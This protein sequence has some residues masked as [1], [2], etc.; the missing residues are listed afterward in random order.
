[1]STVHNE[2][3]HFYVY[4]DASPNAKGDVFANVAAL[5]GDYRSLVEAT[6]EMRDP[7]DV[8]GCMFEMQHRLE[9]CIRM[10]C[11]RYCIDRNKLH[12]KL[13]KAFKDAGE[14]PADFDFAAWTAEVEL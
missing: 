9:T 4:P 2:G 5:A 14:Y 13:V 1:M 3:M 7:Q 12:R 10:M 6:H 8:V 11:G